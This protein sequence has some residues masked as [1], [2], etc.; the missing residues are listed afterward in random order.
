LSF[1]LDGLEDIKK[2]NAPGEDHGDDAEPGKHEDPLL[3]G[4]GIRLQGCDAETYVYPT[5]K[6][7]EPFDHDAQ[8]Y[9]KVELFVSTIIERCVMTG[10]QSGS[11]G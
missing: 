9:R 8:Y 4:S 6:V 7:S 11:K 2:E 3:C 1:R 10:V 5:E